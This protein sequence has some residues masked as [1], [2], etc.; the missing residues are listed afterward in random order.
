MQV[1]DTPEVS[2]EEDGMT[3]S[4]RSIDNSIDSRPNILIEGSNISVN[5]YKRRRTAPHD[6]SYPS[7]P[8]QRSIKAP[9]RGSSA[10]REDSPRTAE[11]KS[12][13]EE[14]DKIV[15]ATPQR[16]MEQVL[17]DAVGQNSDGSGR[18][19]NR[20]API[21]PPLVLQYT[22]I[23][24]LLRLVINESLHVGGRP[25]SAVAEATPLGERI[26]VRS[27][28]SDGR[29]S[30]KV[31]NWS[32]DTSVPDS[33]FFDE[34]DLAK[35]ISC[36]FLNALKF[37]EAGSIC[38]RTML[39]HK[40]RY[41]IISVCDTGTGIPATF[42]PNLF[43]AFAREDGSTTRSKEGLGLGLLVA[44]GLS[45]RLGGDLTCV[46]S[47][48]SDPGRGSEFE[49]RLPMNPNDCVSRPGTPVIETPAPSQVSHPSPESN[50]SSDPMTD[51]SRTVSATETAPSPS[52]SPSQP[53][54]ECTELVNRTAGN[55][56]QGEV[57]L[58]E[59]TRRLSV[60]S[61]STSFLSSQG[62]DR[63][64][65]AKHPLTFLVAED[66]MIN[67]RIL[68]NM[69]G[70]L[71]YKDVYEA[72]NGKEAV[73][74]VGDILDSNSDIPTDMMLD[75]SGDLRADTIAN[76]SGQKFIDVVLMDLWMP[77]MDG[78]EAT[79]KILDM[80]SEHRD[81]ISQQDPDAPLPPEP[82]VLAVSADVTE[83]AIN[84]ATKVGMDGYMTKPYKLNDLAKL[85]LDYCHLKNRCAM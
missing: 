67:R 25:D 16:Q 39:S 37:T 23:R 17:A 47:S 78:Y 82:T 62:F 3:G 28:S 27:R 71:G 1:P 10:D 38:I 76:T 19:M 7:S 32:V 6:W 73:R 14:S 66:N 85:I 83:A 49:I 57:D 59:V 5:P 11:V 63:N 61:R 64:L 50:T 40:G 80:V 42:L 65:A 48:T 55:P 52:I 77:D 21:F 20:P 8:K 54:P 84:K 72:F 70:K 60:A 35:L 4:C 24:E 2:R 13:V 18:P 29:S 58:P 31:I 36:V 41:V 26:E 9:R 68:V 33:L 53:K 75:D 81:R 69:L 30:T 43:K 56:R 44:K 79:E 15:H 46:R 12:V 45:R 51:Q 34:K 22:K 74:V